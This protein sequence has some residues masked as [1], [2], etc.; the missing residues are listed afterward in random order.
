LVSLFERELEVARATDPIV[1]IGRVRRVVGLV[2]EVEGV[3]LPVGAGV[4]IGRRDGTDLPGEVV[5]FRD[6]IVYVMPLGELRGVAR[7]DPVRSTSASQRIGVTEALRGRVIDSFGKAVDGGP[8]PLPEDFYPLYAA[9]PPPMERPRITR[10]LP[11]GIR[12]IDGFTTLGRGQRVGLF[13]G[14]GVGK[15]ILLG[16]IARNTEADVAVLALVGERG[17]EVREFVE[18]DLG[19]EGLRRTVVVVE[20]SDR[21]ALRRVRAPFAATAVAEFFRDRGAHV[22]LLVDSITRTAL[23]QREIGL[24]I[25]EPPATRGFTPSVFALLPRLMERAGPAERG[26]ITGIYNVLVEADDMSEPIS[27]A[28]RGILD[29]HLWLSRPLAERGQYPAVDPLASVSRLMIDVVSEAHQKAASELRGHLAV[30]RDAEDMINIGAYAKGSNPRIDEA[31]LKV[32]PTIDFLK[33]G[34]REKP[35]FADTVARLVAVVAEKPKPAARPKGA[36]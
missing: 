34:I 30:H 28:V 6:D 7:F 16:M 29:G 35:A 31:I 11:T 23:S 1:Q 25:G 9:P 12:A 19:A 32:P 4:R 33:Q 22:L 17:R 5:G 3:T 14:S 24:S 20:T 18:K 10:P 36:A 2:A 26:S 21:P 13:S 8:D 27:D 15:S